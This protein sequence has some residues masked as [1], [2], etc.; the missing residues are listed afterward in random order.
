[1]AV[2]GMQTG[3]LAEGAVHICNVSATA[4]DHM[5][6]VIPNPCFKPRRRARR[7]YSA[8]LICLYQR[9]QHVVDGLLGD[10]AQLGA[11]STDNGV[12]IGMRVGAHR[13]ENGNAR[14]SHAQRCCPQ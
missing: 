10:A 13:T 1:M 11:N 9:R 3:C 4:A 12:D 8:Y 2:G 5:V 7:F 14:T 6:V